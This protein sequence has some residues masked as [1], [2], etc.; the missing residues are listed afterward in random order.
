MRKD[1]AFFGI[2]T[3]VKAFVRCTECRLEGNE[4]IFYTV[5]RPGSVISG[6][7]SQKVR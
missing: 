1:W 4:E 3:H 7:K 5:A 2:K 6:F